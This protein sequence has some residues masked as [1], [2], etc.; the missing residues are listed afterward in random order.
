V[1]ALVSG[2]Q[3]NGVFTYRSGLPLN[4][5]API[6]GG[7]SRPNST[8]QSARIDGDRTRGE[9]ITKWFD[10]S[11]FLLPPSYTMGNVGRTLPDVRSPNLVNVDFSLLKN[12]KVRE[13]ASLQF[14]AEAFNALNRPN[15]WL[16]VTNMGSGQ[17][18]QINSTT[19]LPRVMQL[20]LMLIF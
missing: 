16:P 6:T 20:A 12:T 7:G 15:F 17:F 14:R 10:T 8:G 5:T 13:N 2:W 18:G 1:A 4:I 19:G 3:I 9:E 11:A